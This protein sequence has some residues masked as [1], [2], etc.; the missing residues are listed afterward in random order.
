MNL[1]PPYPEYIRLVDTRRPTGPRTPSPRRPI[2]Q[3]PGAWR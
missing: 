3:L 2:R 1:V